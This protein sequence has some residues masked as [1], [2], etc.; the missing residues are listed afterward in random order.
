MPGVAL[1]IDAAP[2]PDVTAAPMEIGHG[3][4]AAHDFERFFREIDRQVTHR[5][6]EPS[7]LPLILA[8]VEEN[9]AAFR[10]ADQEPVRRARRGS[11]RLDEVVAAT[12]IRDAA[13]K[14]FEKHYLERLARIREDF[15]TAAARGK[16]TADLGE[17]ATAAL[18]GRIGV[19][20]IDADRERP[21]E[22]DMN[23]GALAPAATATDAGDMLD[24]LAE[25]ALRT[26]AMV[27]VTPSAQM[28]T[29]TGL[30]AIFRY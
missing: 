1:N 11:R 29:E 27:V 15:G 16:G 14:V 9:L 10:D 13:W 6:S 3:K 19:L 2:P 24:D 12:E 21:G 28:P 20:L 22:I 5:V 4:I 26:K 17:A 18:A 8:G 23:T 30:A 25:I 7:G